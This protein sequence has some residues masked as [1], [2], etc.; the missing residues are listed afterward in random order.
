MCKIFLLN[1]YIGI[2]V[3]FSDREH[4]FFV[5]FCFYIYRNAYRYD[6]TYNWSLTHLS[7]NHG[8]SH[9]HGTVVTSQSPRWYNRDGESRKGLTRRRGVAV[10]YGIRIGRS[11][12]LLTLVIDLFVK[13]HLIT[14]P[15]YNTWLQQ[16]WE[17]RVLY[18]TVWCCLQVCLDPLPSPSL[19]PPST[20]QVIISS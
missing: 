19:S 5:L 6:V 10:K 13:T 18:L 12:Y 4:N 14:T 9:R 7:V 8:S 3:Q 2:C 11:V 17:I 15:G 16:Y 1:S 20:L